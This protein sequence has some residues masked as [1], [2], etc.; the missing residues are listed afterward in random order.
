MWVTCSTRGIFVVKIA[1]WKSWVPRL[2][3]NKSGPRGDEIEERPRRPVRGGV[4]FLPSVPHRASPSVRS[5]RQS[6]ISTSTSPSRTPL[7]SR[8][9]LSRQAEAAF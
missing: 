2:G 9:T 4:I 1:R 5:C 8:G 3:E 7:T 6:R